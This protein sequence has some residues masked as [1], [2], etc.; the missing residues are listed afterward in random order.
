MISNDK[1][2][3]ASNEPVRVLEGEIQRALEGAIGQSILSVNR[4]AVENLVSRDL[5]RIVIRIQ[6]EF[7]LEKYDFR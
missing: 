4:M 5:L 7:R 2:N 6:P 1:I 3:L